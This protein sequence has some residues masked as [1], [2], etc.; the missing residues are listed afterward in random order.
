LRIE[1]IDLQL[2]RSDAAS[3]LEDPIAVSMETLRMQKLLAG[4]L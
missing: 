2:L 1:L 3:L 4:S